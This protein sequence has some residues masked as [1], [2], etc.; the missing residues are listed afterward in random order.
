MNYL[1]FSQKIKTKHPEY[2]DMDDIALAQAMIK[3][4]PQYSDVTFDKEANPTNLTDKV[5]EVARATGLPGRGMQAI[6][7]GAENLVEGKGLQPSLERAK[8]ATQPGFQPQPGEKIGNFAGEMLDPRGIAMAAG[9][10]AAGEALNLG[11]K[12][13]T[14]LGAFAFGAGDKAMQGLE[15]HGYL[16]LEDAHKMLLSG[17]MSAAVAVPAEGLILKIAGAIAD[18]SAAKAAEKLM[19]GENAPKQLPWVIKQ[20]TT[21]PFQPKE[22]APKMLSHET[23]DLVEGMGRPG[24]DVHIPEVVDVPKFDELTGQ[25]RFRGN[26]YKADVEASESQTPELDEAMKPDLAIRD[27]ETG[28]LYLGEPVDKTHA[29]IIDRYRKA[30]TPIDPEN[31][32]LEYGTHN[33]EEGFKETGEVGVIWKRFESN[34]PKEIVDFELYHKNIGQ[35]ELDEGGEILDPKTGEWVK[36]KVKNPETGKYEA[37][38]PEMEAWSKMIQKIEYDQEGIEGP[39]PELE[40]TPEEQAAYNKVFGNKSPQEIDEH[41]DKIIRPHNVDEGDTWEKKRHEAFTQLGLPDNYNIAKDPLGIAKQ[42]GD[43]MYSRTPAEDAEVLS[44]LQGLVKEFKDKPAFKEYFKD[45]NFSGKEEPILPPVAYT[46]PVVQDVAK[47]SLNQ[48]MGDEPNFKIETPQNLEMRPALKSADVIFSGKSGQTHADLI[49]EY[50]AQGLDLTT[51]EHGF[52]TNT[53]KWI[54]REEGAKLVGQTTPLHSEDLRA[55]QSAGLLPENSPPLLEYK[56]TVVETRIHND[57]SVSPIVQQS[58][59]PPEFVQSSALL[60]GTDKAPALNPE[61]IAGSKSWFESFADRV[62]K[63]TENV[64]KS[65]GPAGE[66]VAQ[67]IAYVRD[68]SKVRAGKFLA[69]FYQYIKP[70]KS[71]NLSVIGT[72]LAD[73]LE[74][75]TPKVKLPPQFVTYTKQ[76]IASIADEA[77]KSNLYIINRAGER[78]PF[79]PRDNYFPRMMKAEIIDKI[80]SGDDKT[81]KKMAQYL[82]ESKQEGSYNVAL[83]QGMLLRRKLVERRYGHLERA[84]ELNFPPEF[85]ERNALKVLPEYF[86]AAYHRLAEMQRFGPKDSAILSKIQQLSD[87]GHDGELALR[88]FNR[89][90]GAEP[91]DTIAKQGMKGLRNVA[92]GSLLQFQTLFLHFGRVAIP[93]YEAGFR[94]AGENFIKAF[95]SVGEKEAIEM[96]Q[97][98]TKAVQEHL[99]EAFGGDTS[100]T[101]KLAE[102]GL[103]YS[104][105]KPLDR[106]FRKYSALTGKD[107]IQNELL[108]RFLKNNYDQKALTE[109]QHLGANTDVIKQNGGLSELEL[110]TLAKR[111]A[112]NT[113]GAP[114]NTTL[115]LWWTSPVGRAYGLFHNYNLVISREMLSLAKRAIE[116]KNAPRLVEMAVGIPLTGYFIHAARKNVFKYDDI[117]YTG[118]KDTDL[119]INVIKSASPIAISADLLLTALQGKQSMLRAAVP[120]AISYPIDVLG[121][122]IPAARGNQKAQKRLVG[123]IP[124]LGRLAKSQLQ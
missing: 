26:K 16:K 67:D 80:I 45:V 2:K 36:R 115:P 52:E 90:V 84:R 55:K 99:Q 108:P 15:N 11:W 13:T 17:I 87:Q 76:A 18:R 23:P 98:L 40:I 72:A 8:A 31:P 54:T 29:D 32:N 88:M 82:V 33:E 93:A 21:S 22:T 49:K 25:K 35:K 47:E 57:T 110:N 91:M 38:H 1:E 9:G 70:Y 4:F 3:K 79:Q 48:A 114:D 96:G 102:F 34:D 30:P 86:Q 50:M 37:T 58:K 120:S 66:Q 89:I 62:A 68:V 74:G 92:T 101:G 105:L 81:M 24:E 95:T 27:K 111:F 113:Q 6:G 112:D 123:D 14:A 5:K 103:N 73:E 106:F 10:G 39:H 61:I 75:R 63:S 78:V 56:P 43:L 118:D 109:L 97:N 71:K 53:Q 7:V 107:W 121:D 51:A 59:V 19:T 122:I 104:G 12:G 65:Y 77:E 116:T 28:Q 117:K 60:Y 85:Y 119:A 64:F 42:L 83:K 20:G 69:G 94:T 46:N 100:K 124:V 44:K 41:L